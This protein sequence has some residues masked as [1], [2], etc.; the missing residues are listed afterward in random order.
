MFPRILR[1]ALL[2]SCVGCSLFAAEPPPPLRAAS[3]EEI[4]LLNEVLQAVAD[5]WRRWAY[6]EHRVLRDAAGRIKSE[7]TLRYDPSKPYAEQWTPLKIEGRE[8]TARDLAKYRRRG[9]E[10]DPERPATRRRQIPTLGESIDVN[11]SM[12]AAETGAHWVFEIPLRQMARGNMR[13]PPEKF[14]V[15]ARVAKTGRT[16]ENISVLLRE[17]FRSMLVIKVK[18]G[19]ATLDFARIDPR[20]PPA[21]V[22]IEGDV[23]WS[24]MFFGSGRS[25]TLKREALKHVKPYDE[26]FE[27]KIG[28]LKALD[29]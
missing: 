19:D 25:L 4:A 9:E 13:F 29:F 6:T 15:Q 24:I 18:A 7:Q 27:V 16:L 5:D 23:D 21:L 11:G 12:I 20:F 26:R 10:A 2:S 17:S 28:T 8:P 22:S 1:L 3:A 14:R